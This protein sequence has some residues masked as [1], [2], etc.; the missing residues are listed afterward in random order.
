MHL[1]VM[2]AYATAGMGRNPVRHGILPFAIG[3]TPE[4]QEPVAI[5]KSTRFKQSGSVR[6]AI[7]R[8][9]SRNPRAPDLG[10]AVILTQAV[11]T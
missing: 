4:K 2:N 5:P 7:A 8:A 9:A 11:A 6:A 1:A 10:S 3:S